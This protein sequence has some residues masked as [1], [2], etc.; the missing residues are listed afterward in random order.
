MTHT[1]I[2][3]HHF[4]LSTLEDVLLHGVL[5]DETIDADMRLLADTMRAGHRLQ[6][7]LRIPVALRCQKNQHHA[8]KYHPE[9]VL[10]SKMI[11]VSAVSRLIP[12]PPARVES[13]NAKSGEPGALKWAILF[14]RASD[15]TMPSRRWWT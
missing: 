12:K 9:K 8:T 5:A 2:L 13:R 3:E 15:E 11:T 7:V 1:G 10:T 4:L 14:L 6:I